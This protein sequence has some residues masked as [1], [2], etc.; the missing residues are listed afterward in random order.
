MDITFCNLHNSESSILEDFL[1]SALFIPKG[2]PALDKS[3]IKSP[4]LNKYIK[5]WGKNKSDIA[6]K[7]TFK[8]ETI[9]LIWGRKFKE[10][11][12]GFGY[13]DDYTPELSIAVLSP[14]RNKG[15]GT[16]LIKKI[17]ESYRKIGCQKI[18]LSVHK[19]NPAYGLYI[20]NGF[21]AVREIDDS[22]VMVRN[23]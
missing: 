14:Y 9:A 8:N 15:I 23:L 17:T 11:S 2:Q 13:I 1:F 10:N 12:P 3:I 5:N 19:L 22:I 18:S 16:E 7:A 4:E 21:T 6:I 20:R